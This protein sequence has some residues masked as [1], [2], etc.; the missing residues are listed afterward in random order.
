[1]PE[2]RTLFLLRRSESTK[3]SRRAEGEARVSSADDETERLEP[4]REGR[5]RFCAGDRAVFRNFNMRP[6]FFPAA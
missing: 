2:A 3:L 1:M 6:V 5:R 4:R